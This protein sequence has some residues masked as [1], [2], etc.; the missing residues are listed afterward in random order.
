M[1]AHHT[2]NFVQAEALGE[3]LRALRLERDLTQEQLA[4]AAGINRNHYQLLEEG[5][6]SRRDEQR[7][8]NPTLA[9]LV[10]ICAVLTV[11]VASVVVEV[12][13]PVSGVAVEY[14]RDAAPGGP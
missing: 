7:P 14:G 2:L 11:P 6:S 4:N 12:F 1:A 5:R 9:T 3:R 10:R 13:G 8:S